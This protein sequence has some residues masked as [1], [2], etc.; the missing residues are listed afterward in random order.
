[1][2]LTS[3]RFKILGHVD[4]VI[5]QGN[6]LSS[7][8]DINPGNNVLEVNMTSGLG[9]YINFVVGPLVVFIT[10]NSLGFMGG[11]GAYFY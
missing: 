4:L 3:N 5:L 11:A 1:M 8:T 7:Y 6:F 9:S 10:D 2:T